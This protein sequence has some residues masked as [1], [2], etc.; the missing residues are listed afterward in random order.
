MDF[1]TLIAALGG[2]LGVELDGADGACGLA[3]DGV[4]VVLQDAGDM[5]LVHTDLGEPPPQDPAALFRAMLEAN[6]LYGGTGGAT[7]AVSPSDGHAHLQKY[8]WLERLD[9]EG[10]LL[11]VDRFAETASRWKTLLA[12]YRPAAPGGASAVPAAATAPDAPGAFLPV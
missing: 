7:L 9:A 10:A 12:D 2:K 11:F 4:D 6:F 3:V 1:E 8:T 5:L